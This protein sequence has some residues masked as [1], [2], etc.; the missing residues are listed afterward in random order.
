M[1]VIALASLFLSCT[2]AAATPAPAQFLVKFETTVRL[3]SKSKV[4]TAN[5]ST[6]IIL[7]VNRAWAPIGVDHFYELMTLANGSYYNENG[8]H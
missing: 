6:A 3:S 1:L 7:E 8:T 2:F 5:G 4:T